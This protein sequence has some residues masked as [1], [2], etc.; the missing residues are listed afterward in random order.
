MV[1]YCWHAHFGRRLRVEGIEHRA[2][3]S[4]ASVEVQPGLI[5]KIAAWML[6]PAGCAGME[7]GTPRASLAALSA[8]HD[9][10]V[11]RGLRRTF[12]GGDESMWK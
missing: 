2:D 8:L 10:L 4:V 11:A 3:G 9:L 1:H 5:V 12:S 7:I 6:D